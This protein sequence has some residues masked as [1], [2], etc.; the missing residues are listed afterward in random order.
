MPR[1]ARSRRHPE[2]AIGPEASTDS[3]ESPEAVT[4]PSAG[5]PQRHVPPARAIA[6]AVG[7]VILAAIFVLFAAHAPQ[8]QPGT[9]SSAYVPPPTPTHGAEV[10]YVGVEPIQVDTVS[11]DTDTF[12]TSFYIWWRWRGP[13]DPCPT[14]DIL[15]ST[16]SSNNYVINYSYTNTQ[17]QE[18]PIS[19]PDGERYQ[20]AKISTGVSDPFSISR[21]PLDSQ[22]LRIRIENNTYDYSQL[23][24][25]PDL[26]H[27]SKEPSFEVAGW[28]LTGTSMAQYM[29]RY[30]TD[31][32]YL[33]PTTASNEYSQLTYD[34]GIARP[35]SHFLMKLF[36]PMFVVL[37][38][39]LSALFVKADDFDVRLAMAGTGLLTLIFL[40][41]GYSGD[42][43][44]T[45][46]VV[47]MDEIYALAYAA[48]GITFLRVVYTTTRVHLR[49]TPSGSFVKPD[50]IMVVTLATAFLLG[51]TLLVAL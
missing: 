37:I 16:A 38:A 3:V 50:R 19:L 28:N 21:Y 51:A 4:T 2:A 29:H 43:P 26:T 46:P 20:T 41:Q 14:T 32:G 31:F 23:V 42:L 18:T 6:L 44:A 24:Y 15:N 7:Y 9:E 12:Q 27:M 35:F 5:H 39:G 34:I 33:D 40:Q 11:L 45:S 22:V 49:H 17:G 1:L 25:L 48:V 13:I 10:V 8:T 47:L 36:L 30:S